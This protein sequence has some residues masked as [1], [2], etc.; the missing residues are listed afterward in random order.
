[1]YRILKAV[2]RRFMLNQI[3]ALFLVYL[4][5]RSDWNINEPLITSNSHKVRDAFDFVSD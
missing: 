1:M 4:A 5:R 2:A 3:E